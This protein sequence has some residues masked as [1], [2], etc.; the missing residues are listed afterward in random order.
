MVGLN[1]LNYRHQNDKIKLKLA[2]KIVEFW[3]SEI[4]IKQLE[5]YFKQ[6]VNV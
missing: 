6:T 5:K 4:T 1:T 3:K 2:D